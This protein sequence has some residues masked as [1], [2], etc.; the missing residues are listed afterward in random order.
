ML[1]GWWVRT[2][3]RGEDVF[4]FRVDMAPEAQRARLRASLAAAD[5]LAKAP[6]FYDSLLASCTPIV[7]GMAQ[8]IGGLP[9]DR[10]RLALGY[11]REF[12]RDL[13][14]LAPGYDLATL[15]AA[16]RITLRSQGAD[17]D[18]LLSQVI[19]RGVPGIAVRP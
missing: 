9:I 11:L 16:G 19:R 5:A 12:L 15:R 3:V 10:R 4:L 13:R 7:H 14:A 2:H 1:L 8:R 6:W 17:A 18:P